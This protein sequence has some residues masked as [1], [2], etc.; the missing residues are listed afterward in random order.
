MERFPIIF[1]MVKDNYMKFKQEE[2]KKN[3]N[4]VISSFEEYFKSLNYIEHENVEMNSK[5][6]DTVYFIGS[7][8]SVY[9]K[10]IFN[11]TIPDKGFYLIQRCLR[12]QNLK[13]LFKDDIPNWGSYF[14]AI[15]TLAPYIRCN[16]IISEAWYFL[17]TV[18]KID[19]ND[20]MVR[21]ASSD[22]ELLDFWQT[23]DNGPIVEVDG[24]PIEYYKH[25]YG[26]KELKGKNLNFALR[27]GNSNEFK[28][29]GNLI[30]IEKDEK[31]IAMEL[32]FGVSTLLCRKFGLINPIQTSLISTVIPFKDE[33]IKF[34]D[35]I[36]VV[37][38]LLKEGLRPNSSN[39]RGRVLKQYIRGINIWKEKLGY[40]TD[41]IKEFAN[42]YEYEEYK[43]VSNIGDE[44]LKYMEVI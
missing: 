30:V 43:T 31:K 38:H 24:Q 33:T 27:Q 14:K 18:L 19:K 13:I 8:I 11:N 3:T 22:E 7:T 20:I 35:C 15:G 42:K 2:I 16:E 28:D 9:K 41:E 40:T 5:I 39:T 4:F 12:S 10:H 32:T 6:D 36:C 23:L 21:V 17:N 29:I 44:L 1:Y 25:K 26:H 37:V 34:S